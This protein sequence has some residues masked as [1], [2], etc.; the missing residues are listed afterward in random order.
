MKNKKIIC[1]MWLLALAPVA[2]VVLAWPHLPQ[3]VPFNWSL[4]GQ[5]TKYVSPTALWG[6]AAF[7]PALAVLHQFLPR[8]DPK[9]KNYEKF[10]RTYE[11]MA[12]L[13]MLLMA[14]VMAITLSEGLWP[15]R[16]NVGKAICLAIGVLFLLLGN[17]MGK[18]KSNWFMGIRTPWSLSDPDVWNK[19]QRLGGWVFFLSGGLLIPLTLL[20]PP[21]VTFGVFFVILF[22]GIALTYYKSWKWFQE[23]QGA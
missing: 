10:Q 1:F 6:L 23:K 4:N 3:Q 18:V 21:T 16:I 7:S 19:T 22:G 8:F 11:V 15:G 9:R 17:L 14:V 2:M 13:V 20:A 5:V 12:I